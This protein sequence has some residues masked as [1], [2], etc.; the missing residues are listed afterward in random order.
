MTGSSWSIT[1]G[2][3]SGAAGSVYADKVVIGAVTA[4]SQAVEAATS[5]SSAFIADT[6]NDGLLGLAFSSINTIS[7]TQQT[8]FFDTVKS[9]LHMPVFTVR[10]RKGAAGSFD[11]G[12]I[13]STKYTGGITYIDVSTVNGF[14]EFD[15]GGY[16]IGNG[17]TVKTQIG[18]SIADTGTSLLYLPTAL[19][20]A[21]YKQVKGATN[22]AKNG[23]WIFP[24]S[25]TLPSLTITI[26]SGAFTIPGSYMNYSPVSAKQCFGGLQAN[27]GIGFSILGDIFLKSVFTVF[28]QTQ[29]TP[30]LGFAVPT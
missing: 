8:T 4:T 1:Y 9:T 6:A 22:S 7:P 17:A 11:F 15:A 12:W 3:A 28:D 27:T 18:D 25:A 26:G 24:C 16:K 20:K 19:V 10:L 23:G 5:V 29:A 21:Y 14:W 2:D 13:D 30:R